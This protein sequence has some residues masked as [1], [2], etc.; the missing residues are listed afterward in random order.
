[1]RHIFIWKESIHRHRLGGFVIPRGK[2]AKNTKK[3]KKCLRFL[4]SIVALVQSWVLASSADS[5]GG[6]PV[7][8]LPGQS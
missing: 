3:R 1:M 7:G 5:G 6:A 2:N 4:L 8:A